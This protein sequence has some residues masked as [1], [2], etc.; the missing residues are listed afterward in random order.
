[1]PNGFIG[2]AQ[3]FMVRALNGGAVAN[4][5]NTQR[6]AGNN[7]QFHKTSGEDSRMWLIL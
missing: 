1:V 4:F 6:V 3:G 5:T 2:T 7:T